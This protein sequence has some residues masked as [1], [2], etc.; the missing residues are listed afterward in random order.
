MN[1]TWL[2]SE[3][4][5]LLELGHESR[6]AGRNALTLHERERD[7]SENVLRMHFVIKVHI[8]RLIVMGEGLIILIIFPSCTYA[9]LH[10]REIFQ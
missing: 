10:S 6:L 3:V 7:G 4:L 1:L 9:L 5:V 2:L 8:I